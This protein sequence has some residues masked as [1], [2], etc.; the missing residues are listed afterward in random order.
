MK[1]TAMKAN[2]ETTTTTTEQK[3]EGNNMNSNTIFPK[4]REE[5]KAET[6]RREADIFFYI[7]NGYFPSWA[8][9][10]RND[11]ERGIKQ[12]STV[13]RWEQ[14]KTGK[15]TREKAVELARKRAAKEIEIRLEKKLARL[16][17]AEKAPAIS[18]GSVSVEWKKNSTWGANPTALFLSIGQG[19]TSGHASGCGYDKESTAI[20]EAFNSSPSALRV[21]YELGEDAL[22]RGESPKSKTAASGY[23]WGSCIGYGAGYDVL[24]YWEGGVGSDCFWRILEKAGYKIRK[25]G[26]GKMFDCYTISREG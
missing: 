20:A 4:L 7:D 21:L 3:K 16:D 6:V 9:Q 1:R 25:A 23:S 19:E 11:R 8:E 26:S 18:S 5:V 17:E 12:Y 10:N 24:P 22:T 2:N 15:I 13:T 14:Y